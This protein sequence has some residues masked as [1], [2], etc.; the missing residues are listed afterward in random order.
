[1]EILKTIRKGNLKTSL[2]VFVFCFLPISF[3]FF[4][5]ERFAFTLVEFEI[6]TILL[7]SPVFA[8]FVFL[9]LV[10]CT[11]LFWI[12]TKSYKGKF[13]WKWCFRMVPVAILTAVLIKLLLFFSMNPY[14]TAEK[15]TGEEA[16]TY[17]KTLIPDHE[18]PLVGVWKEDCEYGHGFAFDKAGNGK[19]ATVFFGPGGITFAEGFQNR[20]S[21]HDVS[22]YR[23]V[24]NDKIDIQLDGVFLAFR[25][26][27]MIETKID[28]GVGPDI[29]QDL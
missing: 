17:L 20:S 8:L 14:F 3:Y 24:N 5:L 23:H 18:Y 25:R 9:F 15:Y 6:F 11:I 7:F 22:N 2:L 21:I 10:F 26:C 1:M 13:A 27:A 16:K 19:Y 4:V 28:A 29:D 12:G